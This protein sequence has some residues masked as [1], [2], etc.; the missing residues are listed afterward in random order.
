MSSTLP[1][2]PGQC[3]RP[4][5]PTQ[6]GTYALTP[7]P[8]PPN[9]DVYSDSPMAYYLPV[10]RNLRNFPTISLYTSVEFCNFI[11]LFYQNFLMCVR[12]GMKNRN[13]W[14]GLL[15]LDA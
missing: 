1:L 4:Q 12:R 10:R 11:K 3:L 2:R 8:A 7:C 5:C 14:R 6:T 13:K 15:D 9:F